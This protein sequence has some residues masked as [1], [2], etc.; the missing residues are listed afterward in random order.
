VEAELPSRFRRL[1]PGDNLHE[2]LEDFYPRNSFEVNGESFH[3]E[4]LEQICRFIGA[5]PDEFKAV[6][7]FLVREPENEY[8]ANAVAVYIHEK[9]VGYVPKGQAPLFSEF[10]KQHGDRIW[11]F[12]AVR[13]VSSLG[14]YRVRFFAQSPFSLD[15]SA[16]PII[17]VTGFTQID[18][19]DEM[20]GRLAFEGLSEHNPLITWRYEQVGNDELV[21]FCGPLKV[22]LE[23]GTA[24]ASVSESSVPKNYGVIHISINGTRVGKIWEINENFHLLDQRL[25][26]LNGLALSSMNGFSGRAD[27]AYFWF[28]NDLKPKAEELPPPIEDWIHSRFHDD[29]SDGGHTRF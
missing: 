6:D 17:D 20:D 8:D 4:E 2:L 18:F 22:H 13:F 10:L 19:D 7:A 1:Y 5:V 24:S 25:A 16:L 11:V 14:H 3:K 26:E 15:E 23:R 28:T 27:Q 21:S 29:E 9:K 12:A